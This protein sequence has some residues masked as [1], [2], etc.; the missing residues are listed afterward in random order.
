MRTAAAGAV[1]ARYLGPRRIT[2]I[3]MPHR[4]GVGKRPCACGALL[5]RGRRLRLFG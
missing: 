5:S 4:D 1:A 2:R 3:G